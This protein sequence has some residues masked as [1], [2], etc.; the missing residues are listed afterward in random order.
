MARFVLRGR[1][2]EIHAPTSW[3][4]LPCSATGSLASEG[5]SIALHRNAQS[6]FAVGR[7]WADR[8]VGPALLQPPCS[9]N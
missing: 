7:E 5:H 4:A 3:M 9:I 2:E 1:T 8:R 6:F